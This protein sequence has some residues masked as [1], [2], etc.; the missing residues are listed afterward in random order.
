MMEWTANELAWRREIALHTKT[1]SPRNLLFFPRLFVQKKHGVDDDDDVQH[2]WIF[3]LFPFFVITIALLLDGQAAAVIVLASFRFRS[4]SSFRLPIMMQHSTVCVCTTK[5]I[6]WVTFLFLLRISGCC[7]RRYSLTS[8]WW[9]HQNKKYSR[10]RRP[11]RKFV[12][13]W[14]LCH[15][16][17]NVSI[18]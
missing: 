10:R 11:T 4:P 5:N 16:E 2:G 12:I 9:S 6:K 7:S 8:L 3:H 15:K 13:I 14:F 1:I 17:S 18:S